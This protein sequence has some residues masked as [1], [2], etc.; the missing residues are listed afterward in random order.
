MTRALMD[1]MIAAARQERA[2]QI[3]LMSSKTQ[4]RIMELRFEILQAKRV[5][6]AVY[7]SRGWPDEEQTGESR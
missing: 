3:R 4:Q 7:G 2:R 6:R 5:L 1:E